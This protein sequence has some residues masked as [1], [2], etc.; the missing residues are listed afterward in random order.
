MM[1]TPRFALT[2]TAI[3]LLVGCPADDGGTDEVD[4]TLVAPRERTRGM[5]LE[6]R[7]FLHDYDWRSDEGDAVLEL[8][9]TAPMV[10]A[11]WINLQYLASITFRK[12]IREISIPTTIKIIM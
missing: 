4:T 5:N 9:M 2:L 3:P 10:V 8:V 12:C 11:N 6:G 7:S 1:K